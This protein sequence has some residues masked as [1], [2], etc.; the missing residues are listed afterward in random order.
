MKKALLMMGVGVGISVSAQTFTVDDTLSSGMSTT[1]YVLDSNA[2][3][4]SAVTG[5]GVTWDYSSLLGYNPTM[6][7]LDNVNDASTTTHAADFP[8]SDYNDDLSTGASL[9]F[10]NSPDSMTVQG[11]VFNVDTYT[12]VIKHS[13]N[14]MVALKFPMV[15]G[16]TYTDNS[17]G[18]VEVASQTGTTIGVATVTVDG[19]GTLKVGL[20]THTNVLR[21][22]LQ[23]T[24]GTSI[25]VGPFPPSTGT[26]TRTIYSYFD[27]ANDKQAIFVHAT[28]DVQ[29]D[30]ATDN[31]TAVYYS[32]LPSF[33]GVEE[34]ASIPFSIYPNP[35]A[36]QITLQSDGTA[37][38]FHVINALGEVVVTSTKPQ[39]MEVIDIST[40]PTGIY[41]IQIRKGDLISNQ[42]LIVE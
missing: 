2:V 29:T 25:T 41:I 19:F 42:K 38:S 20:N 37:D 32:S 30:L 26:V 17:A 31:Y 10:T 8:T 23:E 16:D 6:T 27:L 11:F 3:N 5:T 7:N 13:A 12:A 39:S 35:A 36:N 14:P 1:Y 33:A 22:K 40:L 24:I 15:V 28:I 34:N 18:T 4:L 9:F 21:V